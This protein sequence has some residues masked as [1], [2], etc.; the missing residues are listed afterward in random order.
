MKEAEAAE[1]NMSAPSGERKREE[2]EG[3]R[4]GRRGRGRRHT[5]NNVKEMKCSAQ[6]VFRFTIVLPQTECLSTFDAIPSTMSAK[7]HYSVEKKK[8]TPAQN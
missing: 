2:R 5:G 7:S 4:K 3:V 8:K 1:R 6:H